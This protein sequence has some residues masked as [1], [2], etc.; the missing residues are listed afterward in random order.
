MLSINSHHIQ[1]L[2]PSTRANPQQKLAFSQSYT[3]LPG[4]TKGSNQ[5]LHLSINS[6]LTIPLST[7][8]NL[9]LSP[10][11]SISL[12]RAVKQGSL[13]TRADMSVHRPTAQ[14]GESPSS[15]RGVMSRQA[16]SCSISTVLRG[17]RQNGMRL[18]KCF[19]YKTFFLLNTKNY[20]THLIHMYL[21]YC[22]NMNTLTDAHKQ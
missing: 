15:P 11:P 17:D 6:S 8:L 19:K 9:P 18:D 13:R 20:R 22:P 14:R 5:L 21:F 7:L 16:T 2:E 3:D 12:C 10:P 1:N 4:N